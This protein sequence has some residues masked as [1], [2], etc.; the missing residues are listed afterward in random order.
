MCGSGPPIQLQ[1]LQSIPSLSPV[2]ATLGYSPFPKYSSSCFAGVGPFTQNA[3]IFFT[4]SNPTNFSG[5]RSDATSMSGSLPSFS[6]WSESL[7]PFP[8]QTICLR[9][10]STR[11]ILIC[12]LGNLHMFLTTS[13]LLFWFPVTQGKNI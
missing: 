8:F 6:S 12:I 10:S 4:S 3:S 2:V 7:F 1:L 5:L 13:C 11:P 9:L